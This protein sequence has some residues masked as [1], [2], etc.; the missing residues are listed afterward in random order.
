M[1]YQIHLPIFEGPFDLLFHLIKQQKIDLK[2]IPIAEI[3]EQYLNYLTALEEIDL[4]MAGE[5]LVM[6]A[7]LLSIKVRMLLPEPAAADETEEEPVDP[8]QLLI[9][10]LLEYNRYKEAAAELDRLSR[11]RE[12]LFPRGAVIPLSSL[13]CRYTRPVGDLTVRDLKAAMESLSAVAEP[14]DLTPIIPEV[15]V[16]VR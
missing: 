3:T 12:K 15:R 8:Q 2:E 16:T 14:P 10:R 6:A 7:T 1:A 4:D 13:G 5:F 11:G 9:A